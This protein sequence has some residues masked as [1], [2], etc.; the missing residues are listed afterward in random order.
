[1]E[2]HNERDTPLLQYACR[3]LIPRTQYVASIFDFLN[4]AYGSRC[5]K[6]QGYD[7][8]VCTASEAEALPSSK[9][10][11]A[12]GRAVGM[13]DGPCIELKPSHSC[14]DLFQATF[15][16]SVC[17]KGSAAHWTTCPTHD[18]HG[19]N[20]TTHIIDV[21]NLREMSASKGCK[22]YPG[23]RYSAATVHDLPV[24]RPAHHMPHARDRS[25]L[26]AILLRFV[27]CLG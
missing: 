6:V 15:R 7:I 16:D 9:D 10:G 19:A 21:V 12:I 8:A 26:A 18:S 25:G 24:S 17:N 20:N 22:V 2:Q 4:L 5:T 23:S 13:Y 3:P 27:V 14:Q 11:L 1:M